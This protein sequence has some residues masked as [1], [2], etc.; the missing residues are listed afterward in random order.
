MVVFAEVDEREV[1]E[2]PIVHLGADPVQLEAHRYPLAGKGNA[3]VRLGISP[4]EGPSDQWRWISLDLTERYLLDLLWAN[5]ETFLVLTVSRDQRHLAWDRYNRDGA[6]QGRVY[7]ETSPYWINRPGRSYVSS[8]GLLVTT[9]ERTG[10][11]RV[12]VIDE[13]GQARDIA[14]PDGEAVV[15][16]ILNVH[17]EETT[18]YVWMTR[19][20][21]LERTIVAVNWSTGSLTELTPDPGW[22]QGIVAPDG[23]SWVDQVS[24]WD[25]APETRW[26]SRQ[27]PE[28][29]KVLYAPEATRRELGLVRPTLFELEVAPRVVVNGIFYPP[30]G[31][32]P[33]GGWPMV[34]F[35]YGGPHVQM[36]TAH[37]DATVDPPAQYLVNRGFAVMKVDSRGSA[38]R[39]VDFERPLFR[40][41]GR[42]ELVDQRSAV[43]YAIRRWPI[44]P[45]RIGIFG[46]SYGGY[47]TI[48]AL[49]MAPEVFRVGVAVAPVTDF[50]WYD[51][52]YT[53]RYLGTPDANESGYEDTSVVNKAD[54]LQG[55]LLI[56]H[57]MV[58]ENVHFRHTA[59]F[60]QALIRAGKDVDL[61]LLP[62]SRH[63]VQGFENLL[64]R[65]RRT[66]T[67]FEEHL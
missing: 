65:T 6:Y 50:R 4:V 45:Q 26:V 56:I 66:V 24:N 27:A 51:T 34:V 33:A 19:H 36:V 14:L 16:D 60:L 46:G 8:T 49:L 42:V 31:D 7:E 3:Q 9:S 18:A 48:R 12:L 61:V 59:Q 15:I 67:Y 41:F 55:K 62:E 30:I 64:Y 21:A 40:H 63:M 13:K 11:R 2:F 32:P 23:Q 54:R 38:N 22:H 57:G 43:A 44:N 28:A 29:P 47:M 20:R 17:W 25:V 10:F 53:E 52:G 39:G 37:W 35:V 5:D 1:P 58:D